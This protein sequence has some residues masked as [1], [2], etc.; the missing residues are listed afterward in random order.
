MAV[1][2]FK[3]DPSKK[4]PKKEYIDLS[5]AHQRHKKLHDSYKKIA[6]GLLVVNLFLFLYIIFVK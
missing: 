2:I 3:P 4:K 5:I 1:I 6:L